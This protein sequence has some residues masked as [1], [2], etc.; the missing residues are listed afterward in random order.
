MLD[1]L[2]FVIRTPLLR[3]FFLIWTV[4]ALLRSRRVTAPAAADLRRRLGVLPR[5]SRS[6]CCSRVFAVLIAAEM[7]AVPI[8]M[9]GYGILIERFGLLAGLLLLGIGNAV[10]GCYAVANGAARRL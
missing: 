7:T 3:T 8:S 1:G 10:L 2:R 6:A 9:L 4:G 5:R